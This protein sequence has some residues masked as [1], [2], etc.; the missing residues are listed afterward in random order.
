[1]SF[2]F[3]PSPRLLDSPTG[4]YL[5]GDV[6]DALKI[7][8]SLALPDSCEIVIIGGGIAG[9]ALAVRFWHLGL[10]AETILI[11]QAPALVAPLFAQMD[12]LK[13]RV[14]RSP[15]EHHLGAEY[16]RDCEML[17]FARANWR[18]LTDIERKEIRMAQSGQRSVVP[19]D[20]FRAYIRHVVE[21][22]AIARQVR[23]GVVQVVRA[24]GPYHFVV[25]IDGHH[26]AARY[27]IWAIGERPR[28]LPSQY[29][30]DLSE[31]RNLVVQW[32]EPHLSFEVEHAIV[33]GAGMS[34]AHLLLNLREAGAHVTWVVRGQEK[35]QCTDVD[36]RYFRPEGLAYFLSYPHDRRFHVIR[37]QR[38]ASIMLEFAPI[39]RSWEE[40][41]GLTIYRET[42]VTS[43]T[44][45]NTGALIH[46]SNGVKVQADRVYTA[47]GAEPIFSP[48]LVGD[49]PFSQYGQYPALNDDTLEVL[50]YPGAFVSGSLASLSIGPAARNIDG[51][52]IAADRISSCLVQLAERRS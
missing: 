29:L 2:Y 7:D 24:I 44:P 8:N 6:P 1:M 33:V 28:P 13:Q 19:V 26:L 50:H 11:E 21:T 4:R 36:A 10:L 39:L 42:E 40:Q 49:A 25:D 48:L 52:R 35:Y 51:A 20:I 45:T 14:M 43:L 34:A 38:Q 3:V 46:L 27:V 9:I 15:Y 18:H 30:A 31:R 22:H 32:N 16:V 47:L 37:K 41:G 17:D 23:R 5:F 12:A